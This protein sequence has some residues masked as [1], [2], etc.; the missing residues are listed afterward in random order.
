MVSLFWRVFHLGRR[1]ISWSRQFAKAGKNA[2]GLGKMGT[3]W[4]QVFLTP[5]C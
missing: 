4:P 2:R 1:E 5:G 3:R